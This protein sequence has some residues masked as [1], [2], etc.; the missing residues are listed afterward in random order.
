VAAVAAV[1]A[2]AVGVACHAAAAAV[3]DIK[4]TFQFRIKI[5]FIPELRGVLTKR[6]SCRSV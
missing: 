5:F 3:A 2:A 4:N 6:V 1:G